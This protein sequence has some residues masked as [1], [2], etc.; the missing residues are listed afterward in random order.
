LT[1]A[2]DT[3]ARSSDLASMYRRS[4][5]RIVELL[6]T[7]SV[8]NETAVVPAC[9]EWS[10]HDLLAHV[11]G[12][13]LAL[14][15]GDRPTGAVGPW[16][17]GLVDAQRATPASALVERWQKVDAG[18]EPL[19]SGGASLLVIDLVV[20][21]SDLRAA[22]GLPHPTEGPAM[23][24]ATNVLPLI[25]DSLAG[26]LRAAGLAAIAVRHDDNVWSSHDAPAG[27]TL[28]ADPWTAG[29]ALESR[30]TRDELLALGREG[31]PNPYL[32]L[33]DRHSPLPRQS[34][35]ER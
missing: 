7:S 27:W 3:T 9:P 35:G 31:D 28:H 32:E 20:H 14:L 30:R 26:A 11:V 4:R 10:V 33:L 18:L 17:Q 29:R 15:A 8:P 13:P 6:A 12:L 1:P 23:A 22:L 19:L 21:E 2:I 24:D 34:L 16:I 25:L 5:A